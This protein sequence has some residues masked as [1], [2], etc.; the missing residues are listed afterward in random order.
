MKN[1]RII[2]KSTIRTGNTS[3]N[4]GNTSRRSGNFCLM[5]AVF[6]R[7]ALAP[8]QRVPLS[9]RAR[10]TFTSN[11]ATCRSTPARRTRRARSGLTAKQLTFRTP[12]QE[13]KLDEPTDNTDFTDQ[14]ISLPR[15][16]RAI[17]GSR[18]YNL[19]NDMS[20]STEYPA[21]HVGPACHCGEPSGCAVPAAGRAGYFRACSTCTKFARAVI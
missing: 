9:G 6:P 12:R 5:T 20:T 19:R 21:S 4:S 16:I 18:I 15:P 10:S 14:A 3:Q 1:G 7:L 2:A 8:R 11:S 17:R 13:A